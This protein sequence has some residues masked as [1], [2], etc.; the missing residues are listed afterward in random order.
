MYEFKMTSQHG[1]SLLDSFP[2]FFHYL[3]VESVQR[4]VTPNMTLYPIWND[5]NGD[6]QI[7]L[8][9]TLSGFYPGDVRV[10]WLQDGEVVT[11]SPVQRKLQS[12]EEKEKTF[13]LSSQLELDI[14]KWTQGSKFQCKAFQSTTIFKKTTSICSGESL[15]LFHMYVYVSHLL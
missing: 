12:V 15:C 4:V 6:L 8:L 5:D 7:S 2:L 3:C 11:T 13:S 9:C 10:E 1:D 14:G